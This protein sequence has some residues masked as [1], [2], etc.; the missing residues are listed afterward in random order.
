[1]DRR[2]INYLYSAFLFLAFLTMPFWIIQCIIRR[3]PFLQYLK[4]PKLS[5]DRDGRPVLWVQAVSVGEVTAVLP[6]LKLWKETYPHWFIYLTT[7]TVTGQQNAMRSAA[8]FADQ[9]GYFPLDYSL[10]AKRSI[11]RVRPTL[12]LAAE[13]ELW[14]NFLRILKEKGTPT[15]IINGRISDRSY[16]RYSLL[17]GLLGPVWQLIDTFCLQTELDAQRFASLGVPTEKMI[18]TGNIKFDVDY[19]VITSEDVS[20]L[21]QE[22]GWESGQCHIL[23]AASTHPGEEEKILKVFQRLRREFSCGLI[24]APRHPHRRD[25]VERLIHASGLSWKRRSESGKT[26]SAIRHDIL[27]LDTFG[28]LALAY[29]AGE[30]VFVGG[31]WTNVGGHNILEAAAQR[32]A[33]AYGPHMEDFHEVEA[34][35]REA[36]VGFIVQGEDEL[37]ELTRDCWSRME[38]WHALGERAYSE[39]LRHRGA[40]RATIESLMGKEGIS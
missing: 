22:L 35:F 2:L 26:S 15:G 31:S 39:V 33:V 14:P 11:A 36:G 7:T 21:R 6:F 18:I 9:I 4:V 37:I 25:E 23:T 38:H 3:K 1:M 20:I 17:R 28:E 12:F 29:S 40:T 30:M 34:I 27:L 5:P 16:Q 8:Q 10:I 13:S 19:P 32:R 24:L